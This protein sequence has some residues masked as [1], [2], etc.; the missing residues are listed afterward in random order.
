M[1]YPFLPVPVSSPAFNVQVS[2]VVTRAGLSLIAHVAIVYV[3]A[4]PRGLGCA[5]PHP[6]RLPKTP[7]RSAQ[8]P[9]GLGCAPLHPPRLLKTPVRSAQSPRGLVAPM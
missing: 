9:R 4:S 6:P 8:S 1:T 5:L 3:N 7:V 2:R